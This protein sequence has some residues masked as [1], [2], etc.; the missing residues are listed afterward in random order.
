MAYAAAGRG[1]VVAE[2]DEDPRLG[3]LVHRLL[4]SRRRRS[5]LCRRR[6]FGLLSTPSPVR[7]P[8]GVASVARAF[9]LSSLLARRSTAISFLAAASLAFWRRSPWGRN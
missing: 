1:A 3:M 5:P 8:G 4:P 6:R 2:V 7:L 9:S